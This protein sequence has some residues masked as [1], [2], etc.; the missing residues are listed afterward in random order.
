MRKKYLIKKNNEYR[1]VYNHGISLANK[2]VVIFAYRNDL[3]WRRFGFSVSKKIGNAV[4]RNKVRRK[5]KEIC[6]INADWF[7]DSCDYII[8]ARKGIEDLEY[9][10]IKK[11]VEKLAYKI[12]K[13][14][15]KDF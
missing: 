9:Y 4:Q 6:R 3:S 11:S 8:I 14:I 10:L 13:K 1:K 5:L 12:N 7:C 2:H 15:K